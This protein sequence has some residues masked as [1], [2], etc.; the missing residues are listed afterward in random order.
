VKP[1]PN[2][3]TSNDPTARPGFRTRPRGFREIPIEFIAHHAALA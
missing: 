3:T 2:S 1:T